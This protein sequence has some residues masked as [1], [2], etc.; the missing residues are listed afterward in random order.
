MTRH[1]NI[2]LALGKRTLWFST[3]GQ[4]YKY[5]DEVQY[6]DALDKMG[7]IETADLSNFVANSSR[8][9]YQKQ[10]TVSTM[11]QEEIRGI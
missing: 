6:E 1:V 2:I 3:R 4:S 9:E 11:K 10:I 5:H 8:E 7:A